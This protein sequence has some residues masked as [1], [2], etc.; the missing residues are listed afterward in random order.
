MLQK[1]FKYHGAGNDFLLADNR[2]G[3]LSLSRDQIRH[4]CDRHTGFG[5]DGV[6]LL[7]K[8]LKKDFRMVF[9][10]PDGSGG[11]MCGNG[12]RC[13]VAFAADMGVVSGNFPVEFEAPDGL[14]TAVILNETKNPK[15]KGDARQIRLKMR[16][17]AGIKE[18]PDDNAFFLETGTRHLVKFVTGLDDYPVKERGR[19]L[20]QDPRFASEGTNVNFVEPVILSGA[21]NLL[22]VRTFEK[23]VEDET[24]ACGTGIVAT[25]I[26]A[27]YKGIPGKTSPDGRVSYDVR[28][29]ISDLVVDFIPS[30]QGSGFSA[31]DVWLTGPA[32]IVGTVEC[33][34]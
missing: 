25:A 22:H 27:S 29:S 8:S 3:Y 15:A 32:A 31:T 13:I 2:E 23:G 6:M 16:E 26:A 34:L 9:F 19:V 14:H 24:L 11:M 5:A 21:K 7:E 17:V 4:L 20:R 18:Y 12:G 1:F 30:G 33:F 28:A 10:N